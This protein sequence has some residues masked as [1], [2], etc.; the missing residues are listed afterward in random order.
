MLSEI[1]CILC[2]HYRHRLV[3]R[4]NG[5]QGV[6]CD[7]CGLIFIS[8]RPAWADILA[9]YLKTGD[10]ENLQDAHQ[11]AGLAN[12]IKSLPARH[13]LAI[14]KKY[15]PTGTLLELGPGKG[16]FLTTAKTA[17]YEVS[18]LEVNQKRAEFIT[19]SLGIPCDSTPLS[20]SSRFD[21]KFDLV[22]MR[23][24]LS[25]F[26]DPIAQFRLIHEIIKENGLL[27]F[28]TGN[29]GEADEK[30]FTAVPTFDYPEH[31]FFFGARSL[32]LLLATTGFELLTIRR[33]SVMF[34]SKLEK[35]VLSLKKLKL[36]TNKPANPKTRNKSV[37]QPE[38]KQ[39]LKKFLFIGYDFF[40]EYFFK[41]R[42]GR[43]LPRHG[44]LQTLI[45]I[46]R[47]I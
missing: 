35:I 37:K 17:G 18:G 1:S 12:L 23:D 45:V 5:Y 9:L 7:S 41:Y 40:V 36:S 33:Y 20:S 44:R 24:V 11:A 21:K 3:I 31:L 13:T 47:K 29:L 10:E 43:C 2:H 19:R 27:V 8:P 26:Y 38:L 42:L 25:H 32:R 4:E 28:E 30:Y 14:I 22:Y 16:E 15:Q 46:A 34:V 6:K 39:S